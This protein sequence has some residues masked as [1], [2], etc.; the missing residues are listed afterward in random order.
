MARR[1]A[2]RAPAAARDPACGSTSPRGAAVADVG[3]GAGGMVELLAEHVGATG[4]VYA[5]DGNEAMRAA[6]QAVVEACSV[7]AWVRVLPGD[8]EQQDLRSIVGR[9]RRPGARERG[10]PSP[11]RRGRRA[12]PPRDRA[13][14]RWSP[15]GRGRRAAHQSSSGRLRRRPPGLEGRMRELQQQWFWSTVRPPDLQVTPGGPSGWNQKLLAAGLVEVETRTFLLDL[16]APLS[17]RTREGV[18]DHYVEW[19]ER[20]GHLLD[21]EDIEALEVLVDVDDPRGVL[22]RSDVFRARSPHRL[23]GKEGPLMS[24]QRGQVRVEPSQ[25]R[26]RAYLGG[27]LV[28]DT[29]HPSL[30]WEVPYYPAY[31]MPTADVHAGLVPTGT[32]T[33][34]PSRGDAQHFTVKTATTEATDAAWTYPDSPLEAI[35]DLVRFDWAAMDAWFE[36]DEEVIVHPRDPYT[37]SRHAREQP[38]RR[39]SSSTARSSPTRRGRS[40]SSRPG[41]PVRYYLPQTDLRTSSSPRRTSTRRAPTRAPRGTGQ[42]PSEA[43]SIPTSCG[44]TRRR[45]PR[46]SRSRGWSASTTRRSTSRSTG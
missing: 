31:Y 39:A 38:P 33:H 44:R 23:R 2:A 46:A 4:M 18:R 6:T 1:Q 22:H 43:S 25:K 40:C 15:G 16:P 41:L 19:R 17:L 5:V 45:C 12:A 34:S 24:D 36:E 3:C 32:V 26:V 9:E 13:R 14:S 29:T 11:R 10:G 42:R 21:G 20:F 28:F 27:E 8:L 30:V 37:A 35:R 7:D